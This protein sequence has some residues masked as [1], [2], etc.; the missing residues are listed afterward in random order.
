MENVSPRYGPI[1]GGTEV[2]LVLSNT[3]GVTV[4]NIAMGTSD[5][6]IISG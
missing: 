3:E 4:D 6:P 1:D 5:C 2:T